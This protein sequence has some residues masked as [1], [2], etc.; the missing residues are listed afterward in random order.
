MLL[1]VAQLILNMYILMLEVQEIQTNNK[2]KLLLLKIC[3]FVIFNEL[4]YTHVVL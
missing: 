1:T 2:N 4:W 3:A